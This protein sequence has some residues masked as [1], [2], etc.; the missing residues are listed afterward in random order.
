[1]ATS[2]RRN[3]DAKRSI[4]A[5]VATEHLGQ[6]EFREVAAMSQLTGWLMVADFK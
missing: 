4:V 6:I 5:L 2:N 3:P 1:L